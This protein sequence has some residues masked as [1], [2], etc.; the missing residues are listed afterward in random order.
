MDTLE[1]EARIFTHY[2]I[3]RNANAQAIQLYKD[4]M[5]NSKPDEADRKLVDFMTA[6]P[7]SIGFIDAGLVFHNAS[8]EARRR[9]YVMFA[10]LEANS[11]YYDLF[12]PKKRSPW[13][14]FVIGYSGL[15]AVLKA[16]LGLLL[17]KVVG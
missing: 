12:L 17:V 8:S 4:A 9:L 10:I 7:A 14:V 13:Y 2:L 16:G 6:H 5:N 11:E 1:K 3:G 15:R